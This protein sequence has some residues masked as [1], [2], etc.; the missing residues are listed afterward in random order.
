MKIWNGL[1]IATAFA[2]VSYAAT[3]ALIEAAQ[4]KDQAT[5]KSLLAQ[6]ADAKA[7]TADGTT[8]LHWA[9]HW[10][11]LD[12]V[13][14]LLA[15]G[16]DPKAANRYGVTPIAEAAAT[17]NGAVVERLLKAGVSA[18]T[19]ST[20][21]GE[22]ILMTAARVGNIEA[23]KALLDKGANPNA[24][25]S[26]KGQTAL[27]W[28]ASEGHADIITLLLAKG[29]DPKVLSD[30]RDTTLPKLTAGSPNAPVS[31][32]GLTALSFAARQGNI[33]AVNALLAGGSA[34]NQKDIDGNSA[35]VL[36]ILNKHYDLAQVLIA[37][38]AD[39]NLSNKD[40]RSPLFT[41]VELRNEEYSP[42]PALKD[43]DKATAMDI[44]KSLIDRGANVNAQLTHTV[45]LH[46]FAQDQGDKTMAE[47]A[48]AFMRAARGGDV[49]TMRLLIDKGADPKLANKDGLTA[50]LVAAGVSWADKVRST[51]E[52]A[53][54][55]V[56][57]CVE[58]GLDVNA[59][60]DRGET[61]LHGAA[62]RGANNIATYLVE[63]GAKL[64][65]KNKQGFTAL[66]VADGKGGLAG[67]TR[68]PKPA[69]IALL[70]ELMAKNPGPSAKVTTPEA[71]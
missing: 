34:I 33:D 15:A 52:Q 19:L 39:V 45:E 46:K 48:T 2:A 60:T 27:M 7:F 37:K 21:E 53:L 3:P 10:N 63:K 71:K 44:I 43:T 22:T 30:S 70:K 42:R 54:A 57:L 64:D 61:A 50:L 9:A 12:M 24:K 28:A 49:E 65:A 8:A 51:D 26:F 14:A 66:D 32:G 35:L 62:L 1:V 5:V 23:V 59:A 36:A 6:K 25:E 4:N 17:N 67:T 16:A 56:K 41:A 58:L 29:A 18:D 20:S 13:N 68:D 40:G 11:D 69:T 31:R 55:A 47:G 38:G